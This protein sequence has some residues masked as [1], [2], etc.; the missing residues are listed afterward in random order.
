[1]GIVILTLSNIRGRNKWDGKVLGPFIKELQELKPSSTDDI[2]R[3]LC[4]KLKIYILV[5]VCGGIASRV[6]PLQSWVDAIYQALDKVEEE[7][8]TVLQLVST[9]EV[10]IRIGYDVIGKMGWRVPS[11]AALKKAIIAEIREEP[12][13]GEIPQQSIR[14]AL[15]L[16]TPR[17]KRTM[18]E[19]LKNNVSGLDRSKPAQL[20]LGRAKTLLQ[21][22]LRRNYMNKAII[23]ASKGSPVKKYEQDEWYWIEEPNGRADVYIYDTKGKDEHRFLHVDTKYERFI[24]LS[25]GSVNLRTYIPIAEAITRAQRAY[26]HVELDHGKKFSYNAFME[27]THLRTVLR[28][29]AVVG[30]VACSELDK[31]RLNFLQEVQRSNQMQV[32]IYDLEPGRNYYWYDNAKR[33]YEP[34]HC[35]K[36]FEPGEPEFERL[37]PKMIVCVPP[38]NVIV[39]GGGPTGLTTALHV[40]ENVVTSGG[41]VKLYKSRDAFTKAGSFFER[42]QIVRLDPR[43]IAMLRYHLGTGYEDV[44]IP[45]SGETDSHL[46]N[47]L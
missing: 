44:Y 13:N 35:K 1:M 24:S 28:R 26:M 10:G 38:Q 37:A 23:E 20:L 45:A 15:T 16:I 3:H 34:F 18:I 30:Q 32:S 27:F 5:N 33:T 43:W 19:L 31:A 17:D 41:T 39:I 9:V 7:A 36:K 12:P 22:E 11:D 2:A 29:L 42:A 46:G 6:D 40:V 8:N 14:A 47:T 4:K 25:D 21:R